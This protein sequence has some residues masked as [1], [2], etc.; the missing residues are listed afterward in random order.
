[1]WDVG[2]WTLVVGVGFLVLVGNTTDRPP[3]V[4]VVAEGR[5]DKATKEVEDVSVRTTGNRTRPVVAVHC[6]IAQRAI[7]DAAGPHKPQRVGS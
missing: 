4:P 1:M 7:I 5:V 6:W 2:D 3:V